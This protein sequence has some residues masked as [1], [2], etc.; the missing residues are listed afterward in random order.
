MADLKFYFNV[1]TKKE[2]KIFL[3]LTL[4]PRNFAYICAVLNV[5]DSKFVKY[6]KFRFYCCQFWRKYAAEGYETAVVPVL[7]FRW[8]PCKCILFSVCRSRRL[9]R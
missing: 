6:A 5:G 1:S 7:S 4:A 2:T 8:A 9:G 3:F